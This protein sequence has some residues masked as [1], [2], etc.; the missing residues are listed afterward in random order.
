MIDSIDSQNREKRRFVNVQ[1]V[2]Y[3]FLS[4]RDKSSR[5]INLTRNTKHII[6]KIALVNLIRDN[7]IKS[8][9]GICLILFLFCALPVKAVTSPDCIISKKIVHT[10][11]GNYGQ[12]RLSS[13]VEVEYIFLSKRATEWP[14][15]TVWQYFFNEVSKPKAKLN[16]H[17]INGRYINSYLA[18]SR[19][20]FLSGT[21]FYGISLPKNVDIN[22]TLQYRYKEKYSDIAFIP[23]L[24]IH[25]EGNLKVCSLEVRHPKELAVDFEPYFPFGEQ[26]YSIS[27][28]D[29]EHTYF[30]MSDIPQQD[31]LAAFLFNDLLAAVLITVKEEV[32]LLTPSTP[33]AFVDWYGKMTDLEPSLD[34]LHNN[35][36]GE[37]LVNTNSDLEKLEFI[38]DFVRKNIRYIA[39]MRSVHSIVPHAPSMVYD[40]L[41]GDCKDRAS[42]VSAIARQ[43]GLDVKMALVSVNPR[44]LFH[45]NH[46]NLYDHMICYFE[47]A[48]TAL[49]FDP[50]AR[51]RSFGCLRE[52]IIGRR[53]LILDSENPRFLTINNSNPPSGVQVDIRGNLS[54][55]DSVEA[56]IILSGDVVGTAAY[57]LDNF[58]GAE[59]Q[60]HFAEII[61]SHFCKIGLDNFEV[62]SAEG[63]DIALTAVGNLSDYFIATDKRI[64]CPKAPFNIMDRTIMERRD[65]SL[66]LQD[67]GLLHLELSIVLATDG[68]YDCT[69]DSAVAAIVAPAG[70]HTSMTPEGDFISFSYDYS[71]TSKDISGIDKTNFL[72]VAKWYKTLKTDMYIINREG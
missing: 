27:R 43:I 29:P 10:I 11:K 66:P 18:E 54:H 56:T 21:T 24:Q 31:T 72:T 22:D 65:D 61:T 16:G 7:M 15:F 70:F 63:Q 71:R 60:N 49:F 26:P 38:Y 25:N 14:G 69:A 1:L 32:Q 5:V 58:V 46:T 17:G 67:K 45:G 35:I 34:S 52:E 30:I 8:L 51:Y 41:Y 3:R 39:D 4:S 64:Y 53:A 44:P 20:I 28:P 50:T 47:N 42:L 13:E 6:L 19:D 23:I 40:R 55:L 62:V 12:Y 9:P 2:K 37:S 48:D 36:L 68:L 33:E 59:M 57:L